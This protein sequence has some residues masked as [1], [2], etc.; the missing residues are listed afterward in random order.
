ME[1]ARQHL[2]CPTVPNSLSTCWGPL[3]EG[4]WQWLQL[5]SQAPQTSSATS[6]KLPE[7]QALPHGSSAS[8]W[9]GTEPRAS[10]ATRPLL[11]PLRLMLA[12][13]PPGSDSGPSGTQ[14]CLFMSFHVHTHRKLAAEAPA[15]L[16]SLMRL[17]G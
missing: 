7:P 9:A 10:G 1:T 16:G 15:P 12:P 3:A 6:E 17:T 11:P 2:H 4:R 13:L 14:R 5:P 8:P